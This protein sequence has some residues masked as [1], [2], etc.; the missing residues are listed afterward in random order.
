MHN[1]LSNIIISSFYNARLASDVTTP[2]IRRMNL[3]SLCHIARTVL[4][5]ERL[6][7]P[8]PN[9][10]TSELMRLYSACTRLTLSVVRLILS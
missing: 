2:Y 6:P 4:S 8:N 9:P 3:F 5:S 7:H 1:T 10:G